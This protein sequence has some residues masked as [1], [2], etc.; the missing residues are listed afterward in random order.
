VEALF[1]TV[2]IGTETIRNKQKNTSNGVL[3]V[4][5]IW[6]CTKRISWHKL[7]AFQAM[8]CRNYPLQFEKHK[9]FYHHM[10]TYDGK[11]SYAGQMPL[12]VMFPGTSWCRT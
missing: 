7:I 5:F 11:R 1:F 12:C 3:L 8:D 10:Y 9:A 4:H 6:I 2:G